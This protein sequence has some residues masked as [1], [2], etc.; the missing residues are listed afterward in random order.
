MYF[1]VN[2]VLFEWQH[3]SRETCKLKIYLIDVVRLVVDEHIHRDKSLF[4]K[5]TN[6]SKKVF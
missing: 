2:N 5:R 6:P 4:Q 3:K 1:D